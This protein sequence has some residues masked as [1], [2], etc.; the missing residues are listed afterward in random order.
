MKISHIAINA[1]ADII[2][3]R[4]P[5][6]RRELDLYH[7]AGFSA[8]EVTAHELGVLEHGRLNEKN[9]KEIKT[10]FDDYPFQF[11]VHGPNPLNLLDL[12]MADLERRA[13]AASIEFA[14]RMGSPI[15]VYHARRYLP[16][17]QYMQRGRTQIEE[18]CRQRVWEHEKDCL[19][20]LGNMAEKY[21]IVIA[22]ENAKPYIDRPFYCYGESLAELAAMLEDVG[23]SHVKATLDIGHAF[24]AAKYYRHDFLADI[25]TIA[26]HVCHIHMHDN[27][28]LC[29]ASFEKQSDL[30]VTGRGD[31]HLPPGWGEIPFGKIFSR[32]PD[33]QGNV[34]LELRPRYRDHLAEALSNARSFL[35][36][37]SEPV[38][39]RMQ[40]TA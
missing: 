1:D 25:D 12:D 2:R 7:H 5:V 29:C 10:M 19:R 22:V 32:L 30:V 16:E 6:S 28:G 4:V 31:L 18:D 38:L 20:E 35:T 39:G 23:H 17:E 14:A 11:L 27:Y 15:M 24:L 3:G 21:G 33:Y 36:T 13:F 34:T 37:T 8:V 40:R 9:M 26:P